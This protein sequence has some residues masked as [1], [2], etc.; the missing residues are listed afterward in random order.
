MVCRWL[1]ISPVRTIALVA[2][3]VVT[4][5]AGPGLLCQVRTVCHVCI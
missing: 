2:V 5:Q 4:T 1:F 3:A